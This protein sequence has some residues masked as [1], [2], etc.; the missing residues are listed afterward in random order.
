MFDTPLARW[1]SGLP[2]HYCR[3]DYPKDMSLIREHVMIVF[4]SDRKVLA[5]RRE[6]LHFS[7]SSKSKRGR[8]GDL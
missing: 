1:Y 7:V 4:F 6:V 2:S 3:A 8:P 5:E